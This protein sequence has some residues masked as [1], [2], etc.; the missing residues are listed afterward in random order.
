MYQCEMNFYEAGVRFFQEYQDQAKKIAEL[1]AR[2][3][4][5]EKFKSKIEKLPYYDEWVISYNCAGY[6]D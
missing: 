4:E 5:L 6:H 1:S 2:I 3:E